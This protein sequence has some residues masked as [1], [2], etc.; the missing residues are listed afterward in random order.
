MSKNTSVIISPDAVIL[1]PSY[2]KVIVVVYSCHP[3]DRE[4]PCIGG[5]FSFVHRAV[6][7][8][9]NNGRNGARGTVLPRAPQIRFDVFKVS[10]Y[11]QMD[12]LCVFKNGRIL[13]I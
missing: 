6:L 10:L 12:T 8:I 9:D 4:L 13:S 2:F 3:D 7:F 1:Y 5:N 11:K